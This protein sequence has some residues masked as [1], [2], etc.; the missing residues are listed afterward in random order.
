MHVCICT[1]LDNQFPSA[2]PKSLYFNKILGCK[3]SK[4]DNSWSLLR[5]KWNDPNLYT[6]FEFYE[7]EIINI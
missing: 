3:H 1:N 7:T 5:V 4:V 6:N 2:Q